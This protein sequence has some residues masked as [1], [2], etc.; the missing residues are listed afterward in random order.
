[1]GTNLLVRLSPNGGSFECAPGQTV[2]DAALAAGYWLPHSCRTGTCNSCHLGLL[3]G[4]VEHAPTRPDGTDVPA[5]QCRTCQAVPTAELLLDAPKVPAEPGQRVVTTGA[6]VVDVSRPSHD[7]V[8]I[9]L[10][11]PPAAGFSFT[12]GQYASVILKDGA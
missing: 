1:M 3:E 9:R 4:A 2:L 10:Q 12:A 11:V 8:V 6:K 5:G 7:V